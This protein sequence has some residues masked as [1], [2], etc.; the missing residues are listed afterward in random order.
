MGVLFAL[1]DFGTG[2]SSLTYLK[3]LKVAQLK[4]DQSFVRD[5]F[6]DPDNL[7]IL[8]T[9]VSLS[10]ALHRQVIA[11][12]VETIEHGKILLQLG[13]DLAQGYFIAY[14]MPAHELLG[15]SA[16]WRPDPAWSNLPRVKRDDLLLLVASVYH[17]LWFE[18]IEAFLNGQ[19]EAPPPLEIHQCRFGQW[20]DTEGL[21][22]FGAGAN[23]QPIELLHEQVH[24]LASKLCGLHEQDRNP[25]ALAKL[26]E[27]HGLQDALLEKLKTLLA[28]NYQL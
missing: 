26:G 13:C 14:P 1:D 7:V 21:A 27:L 28:L 3:R 12:G 9:M 25:E 2:Y 10:T 15:W 24:A 17:Q 4:I 18:A 6:E 19:Q 23:I 11:E 16:A 22:R 8:E 5:M 20:L